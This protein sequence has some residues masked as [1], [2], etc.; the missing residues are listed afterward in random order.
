MYVL[1]MMLCII[2]NNTIHRDR[3]KMEII[4]GSK[5]NVHKY[6]NASCVTF[7][8]LLKSMQL[9]NISVQ[10]V[11]FRFSLQPGNLCKYSNKSR[12][13]LYMTV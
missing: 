11:Y 2:L 9:V 6:F 8:L 4:K 3:T 5:T 7:V 12:T 13:I 1:C 10:K